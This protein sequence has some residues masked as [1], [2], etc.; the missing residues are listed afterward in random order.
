MFIKTIK[1]LDPFIQEDRQTPFIQYIS[2]KEKPFI[3]YLFSHMDLLDCRFFGC[4]RRSLFFCTLTIV[5]I[6]FIFNL[7]T[8]ESWFSTLINDCRFYQKNLKSKDSVLAR[9]LFLQ[10]GLVQFLH[11]P[12]YIVTVYL[13]LCFFFPASRN[14]PL[15]LANHEY[16]TIFLIEAI[17]CF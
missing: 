16:F 5:F 6:F 11:C 15:C 1:Y 13:Y 2:P 9:R 4:S 10:F 12:I 14:I 3:Q 8:K 7:F 17:I